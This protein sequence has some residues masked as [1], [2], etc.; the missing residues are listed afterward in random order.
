MSIQIAYATRD[1]TQTQTEPP[2]PSLSHSSYT[3]LAI[4]SSANPSFRFSRPLPLPLP[5]PSTD[6]TLT[7]MPPLRVSPRPPPLR[8]ARKKPPPTDAM[9][10]PFIIAETSLN[11][12]ALSPPTRT[13]Q[14]PST[15]STS[16]SVSEAE[17]E[18]PSYIPTPPLS[19][20]TNSLPLTSHRPASV[21]D[22]AS[23]A[24][25][26]SVHFGPR[27]ARNSKRVPSSLLFDQRRGV[28]IPSAEEFG[29]PT[30][31]YPVVFAPKAPQV[32]FRAAH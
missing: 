3:N 7:A 9:A 23:L 4:D 8:I 25:P 18:S 21:E 24:R 19:D 5:L 14:L 6:P 15:A 2:R 30:I 17:G 13:I 10:P 20:S 1:T 28:E 27:A 29:V 12:V 16:A 31:S 26:E 11:N 32:S 22:K